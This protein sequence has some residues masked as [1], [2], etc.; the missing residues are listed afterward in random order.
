MIKLAGSGLRKKDGLSIVSVLGYL[1]FVAALYAVCIQ[2]FTSVLTRTTALRDGLRTEAEL[3]AVAVSMNVFVRLQMARPL[4]DRRVEFLGAQ[5]V[6][7]N[8]YSGKT[9]GV[10][11]QDHAGKIDPDLLPE[12]VLEGIVAEVLRQDAT[13]QTAALAIIRAGSVQGIANDLADAGLPTRAALQ[14]QLMFRPPSG[15]LRLARAVTSDAV[16][17]ALGATASGDQRYFG[18][19]S[20]GAAFDVVVISPPDRTGMVRVLRTILRRLSINSERYTADRPSMY[21]CRPG[22]DCPEMGGFQTRV[23]VDLCN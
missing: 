2:I 18:E 1:V 9:Y 22:E 4:M 15:G 6:S 12:G 14:L 19:I 16:V 7:C 17:R 5:P 3:N 8:A 21:L 11:I 20:N 10:F 13:L 23:P